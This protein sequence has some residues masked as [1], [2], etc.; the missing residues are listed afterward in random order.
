MKKYALLILLISVFSFQAQALVELR[1]G[2]GAQTPSEDSYIG[3]T[4]GTMSGFNLDAIISPP[5]LPI[6]IGLRYESMGLDL[7][8]A[9]TTVETDMERLSLIINYRFID[10]F[11]YFGLIGTLGFS[12]SLEGTFAGNNAE[13]ESDFTSSLGVEGG[14]SLGLFSLGAEVGYFMAKFEEKNNLLTDIN[15]DGPYAKVLVGVGF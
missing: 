8:T 6:G 1:A 2:Y 4:V 10:L 11:A 7:T 5:L 9:L 15:L 13:F 12:N 3:Q 14:V